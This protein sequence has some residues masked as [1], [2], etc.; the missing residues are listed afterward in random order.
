MLLAAM[1][2]AGAEPARTLM[3]GDTTYDI[4]MARDAGAR[5]IGVAWGYHPVADLETA[6]AHRVLKDSLGLSDGLRLALQELDGV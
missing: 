4:T 6:G 5:P 3:V 2:E 1:A